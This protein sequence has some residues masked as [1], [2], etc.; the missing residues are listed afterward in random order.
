MQAVAL[1]LYRL[2]TW[3]LQP[4]V[5]MRLKRRAAK[6]PLYGK[7]I[8]ERFGHYTQAA[9]SDW[10]W[11][12]AV[13]LGETRAAA[14]LLRELRQQLPDMKLL[15]THGTATGRE[16]GA[17]LLQAGDIQ[18]WQP[19]DS[20]AATQRFFAHF[21]PRIG[22][23]METE[24][25]PNL[26]AA[27]RQAGVPMLLANARLNER[28]LSGALRLRALS[29]PAY[30]SFS[31]ALAQTQDDEQRLQQAGARDVRVLGN[32]KFDVIINPA[33]LLRGQAFKQCLD[34][35]HVILLASSREGEEAQFLEQIRLVAS[36][37]TAQDA[38]YSVA[39]EKPQSIQWL[40]VPRH[41]Q[42]F[43]EVQALCEQHGLSVSRRSQW[44]D[45]PAS[46]DVWL[47]DSMGEM[48]MYY[49]L[50][51]I[52]LLGGSFAPLGGQNLIEAIAAGCPVIMGP[53]TFNFEQAC[54][55]AQ[56]SGAA[57]RVSS[58]NEGI[59]LACKLINQPTQLTQLNEHGQTWLAASKG[60]SQRQACAVATQLISH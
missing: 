15:L 2:L 21:K 44:S 17:K 27:A 30:G 34:R 39:N 19:W 58:M 36:M 9:S 18:V 54:E 40:I 51:D 35:K 10:I 6:E 60:A 28:S 5:R 42:R 16:E 11:I 52:A 37:N 31:V 50:A 12:H 3:A 22:I 32:L 33:L 49:S 8:E 38:I 53:H 56:H 45:A 41:P 46:A 23:V 7:F 59:Q 20:A 1:L 57:L 26:C 48:A 47:G 4:L 25:W 13:S 43:D 55:T 24:I 14:I 29:A